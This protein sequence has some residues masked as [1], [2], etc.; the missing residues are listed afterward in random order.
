LWVKLNI[1][2]A[3]EIGNNN[4]LFGSKRKYKNFCT[5]Q[6]N[7]LYEQPTYSKYLLISD[8]LDARA[9]D[10]ILDLMA[11]APAPAITWCKQYLNQAFN[12]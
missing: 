1:L 5:E 8:S 11:L 3:I 4:E 2:N 9:M 12:N 7:V 10:N 6:S